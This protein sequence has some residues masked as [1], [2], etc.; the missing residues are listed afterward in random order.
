M[1]HPFAGIL[2]PESQVP[3][4]QVPKSQKNESSTPSR[5]S[6]IQGLAALPIF[7]GLSGFGNRLLGADRPDD[8]AKEELDKLAGH[9]LYLVEPKNARR[10]SD[11][12]RQKLGVL[13]P[14]TTNLEGEL[15]D[16]Q[17]WLAW[18]TMNEATE[19]AKDASIDG[20]TPIAAADKP[21]PGGTPHLRVKTLITML[22]PNMWR[23]K[24]DEK[25]YADSKQV[26]A[27]LE[28]MLA[29]QNVEITARSEIFVT[30]KFKNLKNADAVV[31]ELKEHPQVAQ[32]EWDAIATT[33]AL[34]EEGGGVTTQALGEEG[35]PPRPSTRRLGE[36]G[37]PRPTTLA[38]G[39]EG[40]PRPTT[41]AVGEEGGQPPKV[42]TFALGEEG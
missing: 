5:R 30:V 8:A 21:G 41:K 9:R 13:G 3:E 12:V 29:E 18:L 22:A 25:T 2:V 37:G 31:A 39:E 33:L 6:V 10:F 23:T 16:K 7:A 38:V 42:T 27:E 4:S 19:L 34:G 15:K 14:L 28:K 20:V 35:N 1:Q 36:E 26:A 11:R 40:G 17:G 24:P 32:L